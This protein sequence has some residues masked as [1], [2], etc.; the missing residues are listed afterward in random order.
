MLRQVNRFRDRDGH[1]ED[2]GLPVGGWF[3]YGP[4]ERGKF[5]PC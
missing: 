2:R 4:E 3:G 1:R 5:S